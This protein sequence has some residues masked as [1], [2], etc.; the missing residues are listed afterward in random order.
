F[1][2]PIDNLPTVNSVKA[3]QAIPVK[4]SLSGN[5]GLNIFAA[6]YP[7]SPQITCGSGDPVD[8]IGH[9]HRAG[10]DDLSYGPR[11]DQYHYV[12]KTEKSWAGTCRQLIVKLN[13][14]TVHVAN[15]KFK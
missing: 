12:W 10:A 14:G 6:G 8:E 13:D 5:H 9:A 1:F 7:A 11:T 15:F 3:G 4:F 2:Q